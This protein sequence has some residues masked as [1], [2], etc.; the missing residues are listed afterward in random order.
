MNGNDA[1]ES[2]IRFAIQCL[3][4]VPRD[5]PDGYR[6]DIEEGALPALREALGES[7]CDRHGTRPWLPGLEPGTCRLCEIEADQAHDEDPS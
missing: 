5:V 4:P 7:Y 3:H 2:A 1:L 6:A